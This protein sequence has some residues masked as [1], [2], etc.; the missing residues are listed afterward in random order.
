[1]KLTCGHVDTDRMIIHGDNPNQGFLS[2]LVGDGGE[3]GKAG[4]GTG[5]GGGEWGIQSNNSQLL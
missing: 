2:F 3:G 5:Q 1:M 4:R